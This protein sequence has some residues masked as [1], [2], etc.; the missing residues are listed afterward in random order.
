VDHEF[1]TARSTE[2]PV[3][4]AVDRDSE[5]T[6]RE[7]RRRVGREFVAEPADLEELTFTATEA[8]QTVATFVEDTDLSS[9]SVLLWSTGVSEC[10]E[11]HLRSV[12]LQADGDP[13][14]DFCRSKRPAD[15]SCDADR[16]ETVA[17]AVRFPITGSDVSGYGSGMSHSCDGPPEPGTFDATVTVRSDGE[18]S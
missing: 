18:E 14:V 4:F 17:Y 10:H 1:V 15:V 2:E 11:I 6:V 5:Q 7:D 16:T 8:G 3:I 12:T 13:H 9:A